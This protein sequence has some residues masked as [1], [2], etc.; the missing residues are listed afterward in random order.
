MKDTFLE[1]LRWSAACFAA[2]NNKKGMNRRN[3]SMIFK[4][5]WTQYRKAKKKV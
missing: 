4:Q 3:Q 5:A 1:I 2:G